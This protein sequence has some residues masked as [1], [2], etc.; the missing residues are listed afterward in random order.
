MAG[1][2]TGAEDSTPGTDRDEKAGAGEEAAGD[3][4]ELSPE[5]IRFQ[6]EDLVDL[7]T[8]CQ[9]LKLTPRNVT[10]LVNVLKLSNIDWFRVGGDLRARPVKRTVMGLLALAAAYP[11]IMREVLDQIDICYRSSEKPTDKPVSDCLDVG[12][13]PS[14]QR[15]RERYESLVERFQSDATALYQAGKPTDSF[16]AVT[17]DVLQ[18]NTFNVV[19]SFSFVGDPVYLSDDGDGR[20]PAGADGSAESAAGQMEKQVQRT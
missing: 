9:R 5:V 2:E 1:K 13:L 10:R 16:I 3:W 19:R 14:N 15:W 12:N 6:P 7:T 20:N 11:E 18:E 17:L 4:S 8:C